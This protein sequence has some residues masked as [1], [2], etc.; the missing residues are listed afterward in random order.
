MFFIINTFIGRPSISLKPQIL[1]LP[2]ILLTVVNQTSLENQ[3]QN[4]HRRYFNKELI[5]IEEKTIN[6]K[7]L[8]NREA[9]DLEEYKKKIEKIVKKHEEK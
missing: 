2:I 1:C 6:L 9:Y 8:F 5:F 7:E 4:I 3:L